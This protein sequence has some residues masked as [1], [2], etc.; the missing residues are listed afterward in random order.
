MSN[1]RDLS[2]ASAVL[3]VLQNERGTA[4][5]RGL[6]VITPESRWLEI[7]RDVEFDVFRQRREERSMARSEGAGVLSGWVGLGLFETMFLAER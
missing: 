6:Q 4:Q 1:S 3:S 7:R 5:L 2:D